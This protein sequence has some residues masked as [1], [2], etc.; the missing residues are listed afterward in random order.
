MLKYRLKMIM[1]VDLPQMPRHLVNGILEWHKENKKILNNIGANNLKYPWI[2]THI[3][4][5]TSIDNPI[6]LKNTIPGSPWNSEF[7]DLFPDAIEFFECLP[8]LNIERIVLLESIKPVMSHVDKSKS[9]CPNN[10]LEPASYRMYLNDATESDGFY[11][12][13]KPIAEWGNHR[14]ISSASQG[15]EYLTEPLPFRFWK[16]D[17]GKWWALDNFCSQHGSFYKEGDNKVIISVQGKIDASRHSKLLDNSVGMKHIK[18]DELIK[19]EN[20]TQEE[21]AEFEK[22]VNNIPEVAT[23]LVK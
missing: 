13:P 22:I 9:H 18:H 8:L 23:V 19:C 12:Q 2:S 7:V 4:D 1:E 14:A 5:N 20:A 16:T 6:Q 21:F 10:I 11:V 17:I 3:R 15:Y